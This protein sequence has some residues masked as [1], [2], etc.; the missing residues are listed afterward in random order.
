[1]KNR[2]GLSERHNHQ[3]PVVTVFSNPLTLLIFLWFTFL[4]LRCQV[5]A[6]ICG[7]ALE[8]TTYPAT[9]GEQIKA[10]S[11]QE[12]K[13]Q[14]SEKSP[15]SGIDVLK[16]HGEIHEAIPLNLVQ[17]QYPQLPGTSNARLVT[18]DQAPELCGF[19]YVLQQSPRS[20]LNT[21]THDKYD[22]G[23]TQEDSR[24]HTR[25]VS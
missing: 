6:L 9:Y 13:E 10:Y 7:A 25:L 23:Q 4:R 19:L 11:D 1:V 14:L 18:G 15:G 2:R 20:E 16:N 22:H 5:R 8:K 12:A 21:P 17:T 3:Q 24:G